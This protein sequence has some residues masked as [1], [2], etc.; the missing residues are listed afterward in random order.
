MQNILRLLHTCKY[1][2]FDAFICHLKL[3]I[4]TFGIVSI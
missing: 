3:E 4:S 1:Q 2:S